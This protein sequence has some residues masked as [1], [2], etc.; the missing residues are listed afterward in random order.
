MYKKT[1]LG[2]Q[3]TIIFTIYESIIWNKKLIAIFPEPSSSSFFCPT[4]SQKH[5]DSSL[6]F[7][8]DK[9]NQQIFTFKNLEPANVAWN[10]LQLIIF[11]S[12]NSLIVATLNTLPLWNLPD[13]R[14]LANGNAWTGCRLNPCCVTAKW[15]QKAGE[16]STHWYENLADYYQNHSQCLYFGAWMCLTEAVWGQGAHLFICTKAEKEKAIPV[17]FYFFFPPRPW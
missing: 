12:S 3:L 8:N 13:T 16:M 5:Q 4:N 6:P 11:W 14:C 1:H 2:I 9:E 10:N 15:W 7:I 17:F